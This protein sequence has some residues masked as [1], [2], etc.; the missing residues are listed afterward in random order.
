MPS[1]SYVLDEEY[2]YVP[3]VYLLYATNDY[4]RK[5]YYYFGLIIITWE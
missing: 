4:L 3:A 5:Y 2:M 1:V